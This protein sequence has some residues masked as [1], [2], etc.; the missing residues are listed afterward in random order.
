M[1]TVIVNGKK[2]FPILHA[3]TLESGSACK[4]CVADDDD[5]LCAILGADCSSPN[6]Y[7]I[8]E[9]QGIHYEVV[10]GKKY[11]RVEH[12]LAKELGAACKSCVA[13]FDGALCVKLSNRGCVGHR[14]EKGDD[15]MQVGGTHYEDLPIQPFDIMKANFKKEEYEGYLRGNV[16]K[17]LLR[18]QTKNGVEDLKKASHYLDELITFLEV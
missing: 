13:N 9:E 18:Y 10:D 8:E 14:F 15:D 16:I 3:T 2:Y 7:Y 1:E 5:E 17:Y 4:H 6:R 11:N 12:I